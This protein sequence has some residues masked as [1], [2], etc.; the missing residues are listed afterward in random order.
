[1]SDKTH[2]KF[3]AKPDLDLKVRISPLAFE[4]ACRGTVAVAVG[5]VRLHVDEI[6]LYM[7]IPFLHRRV[8]AGSIGPFGV[9]LNPFETQ[10]RAMDMEIRGMIGR[11]E[12]DLNLRGTGDCKAE[13]EITGKLPELLVKESVTV[14]T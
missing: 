4:Y 1:M 13:V 7:R 11:E 14:K 9:R 12:T 5:D 8:R 6:P 3:A 10:L 2:I